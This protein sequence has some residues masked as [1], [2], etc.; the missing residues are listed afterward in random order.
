MARTPRY[1]VDG[2]ENLQRY[3][4][5]ISKSEGLTAEEEAKLALRI[6]REIGLYRVL[7]SVSG[8]LHKLMR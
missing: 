5:S 3:L 7:N 2:G 6:K 1:Q 4:I 8:A